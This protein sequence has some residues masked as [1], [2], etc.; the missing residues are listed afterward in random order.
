MG[1]YVN[2][3]GMSKEQWLAKF[4]ID[5]GNNPP[6]SVSVFPDTLPVCLINNGFFTAAGI[7]YD[8]EELAAFA[9]PTD[10]RQRRWYIVPKAE[11]LK[12]EPSIAKYC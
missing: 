3:V 11:L 2:P 8:D 9:D 12:V 5:E 6:S 7:A 10:P 4:A 1:Y